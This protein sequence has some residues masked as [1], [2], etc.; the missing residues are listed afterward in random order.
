MDR[1]HRLRPIVTLLTLVVLALTAVQAPWS[2]TSLKA[3]ASPGTIAYTPADTLDEIR[4]IEPDG[5]NDRRLW[6]HGIAD[7]QKVYRIYSM[8]WRPDSSEL[9]F[10]STHESWCSINFADVFV[11]GATGGSARRI[12]EAPGC[13]ALAAYPK[14]TVQVPVRNASFDAFVGFVYFQGAPSLQQVAIPAG[15]STVVTFNNVA[16]FGAG[17]LQVAA[18]INPPYREI[19]TG[20][21]VDVPTGG[22]IRTETVFIRGSVST[23]WE[24]HSQTWRHDGSQIGYVLNFNS[25]KRIS[26]NPQPADFGERLLA[27]LGRTCRPSQCTSPGARRR[28]PRTNC[29][30]PAINCSNSTGIYRVTEGSATAG[31]KL[32]SHES[33]EL[34][35][36]LSWLPD[37]SG[38]VY[39]VMEGFEMDTANLY[40]YTFASR[41]A[42]RITNFSGEFAGLPSVAPDGRR[43]A[44]ERF[45]SREDNAAVDVWVV[46]LDGSGLAVPGAQRGASG[47]EPG[48]AAR[49]GSAAHSR[50]AR[51]VTELRAAAAC[52]HSPQPAL[53]GSRFR[54]DNVY[55]CALPRKRGRAWLTNADLRKARVRPWCRPDIAARS[56]S[57]SRCYNSCARRATLVACWKWRARLLTCASGDTMTTAYAGPLR[58]TAGALLCLLAALLVAPA[59]EALRPAGLPSLPSP[60][61]T[62]AL[63]GLPLQFVA[64][65]GQTDPAVRFQARALG[66][67]VFFT[68]GE[69]VL[70]LPAAESGQTA[71]L[72]LRFSGANLAPTITGAA[73]QPG[74]ANYFTGADRARWRTDVPTYGAIVYHQ[75]Y[76][77]VDLHYDGELG[78]LKG[79]YQVAASADPGRI[80]WR[81]DGAA[82]TRI[83]ADGSLRIMLPA[84]AAGSART[85]VEA[86]PIA[87]Q[88]IGGRRVPVDVRYALAPDGSAGFALGAYDMTRPLTIDPALRF[89]TYLGGSGADYGY[90]IAA[91]DEGNVYVAGVTASATFPTV[92]PLQPTNRGGSNAQTDLFVAKLNVGRTAYVYATYLGGTDDDGTRDTAIAVDSHGNAYV[93]GWTASLD[94]P[95]R[96]PIRGALSGINGDAFVTKINPTGSELVF[97]TY[98]GG[99]SYDEARGIAVDSVGNAYITGETHSQDFP[100]TPGAYMERYSGLWDAFVAKLTPTGQ[101]VYATLLGSRTMSNETAFDIA[102]DSVGNASVTGITFAT[103]FPVVN[104]IQPACWR[105]KR[106]LCL[107][108]ERDRQRADLFDV[109]WRCRRGVR[110]RRRHGWRGQHLCDR[111]YLLDHLPDGPG[112]RPDLQ[113]TGR[114]LRDQADGSRQLRLFDLPRRHRGR[115]HR[116][117][118][119]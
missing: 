48:R 101:H 29:C 73:R 3:Q 85:L 81:Y 22:N 18:L 17:K 40:V 79:T 31:E 66:G 10:A 110:L 96:N 5:S 68:P 6:A 38:F 114:P 9:A 28:P 1:R 87:W 16:D 34:I 42:Q 19:K 8:T 95:T 99:G 47:V 74:T 97:S 30:T 64:N 88:E 105:C 94:F 7:P 13:A 80:H 108:A 33:Y 83:D 27:E 12:T 65:A 15:G 36:G 4:L 45:A 92:N 32:V 100:T 71:V 39:S 103:D 52:L 46:N 50:A 91:D 44:F 112:A 14:G 62:A 109:P 58:L 61:A 25:L 20:T 24:V 53:N 89:S 93:T 57:G 84:S 77:G 102:V 75:L 54:P 115:E 118:F 119:Q 11:V 23:P 104:A 26:S 111:L 98:Y 55:G 117:P 113:R 107:E 78:Q 86:A 67:S 43:I 2:A 35:Q 21:A 56:R 116:R 72:R 51:S 63:A 59:L 82:S 41:R 90:G 69:V 37:G 106:R 76:D 49:S 60:A 70:A